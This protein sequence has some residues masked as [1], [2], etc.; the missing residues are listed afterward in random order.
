MEI[1]Q[2]F[3]AFSEYFNFKKYELFHGITRVWRYEM[4]LKKYFGFIVLGSTEC[5]RVRKV[6]SFD[7]L[8]KSNL[9]KQAVWNLVFFICSAS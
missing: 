1:L 6:L 9:K 2:N 8:E 3:V 5:T 7:H 4:Q